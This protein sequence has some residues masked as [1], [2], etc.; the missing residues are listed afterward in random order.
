MQHVEE[1]KELLN[2]SQKVIIVPHSKPDADALG[3]CLAMSAYLKKRGHQPIVISPTDYPDFLKWMDGEKDVLV[4]ENPQHQPLAY[5]HFAEATLLF[6]LDFSAMNRT[7]DLEP[8]IRQFSGKI[9]IIDHHQGKE[10]FAHFELWNEK[11]AATC[12]LVYDFIYLMNDQKLL[13]V[14]IAECLYAGIMTDTGSF[15]HES[16]S[17]RI[18]RIA[19][20]IIDLGVNTARIHHC[21]YDNY[22][23]ERLRFLGFAL[24]Q[25]LQ[26][27]PDYHCAYFAISDD[28]LKQYESKTGDTEG[29]VNYALSIKDVDLAAIF[30][31]RSEGIKISFRSFGEFSVAEFAAKYFNGGGHKNASGGLI[32]DKSLQETVDYFIEKLKYER[33]IL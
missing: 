8:L 10:D 5:Q 22:S 1:L 30:I 13:D 20:D 32:K 11:A 24:S 29:V 31:E 4:F 3:A 16:T 26:V 7:G 15:K 19:A 21:I 14:P 9:V 17:S 2:T 27:L 18:H 25:K 6:C 28:E 33:P 12:E 23:L